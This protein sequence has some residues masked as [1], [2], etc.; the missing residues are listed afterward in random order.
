MAKVLINKV[1]RYIRGHGTDL[2]VCY[3]LRENVRAKLEVALDEGRSV[4]FGRA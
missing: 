2:V 1:V 3:T 4:S